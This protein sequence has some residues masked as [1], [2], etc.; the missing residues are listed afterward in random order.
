MDWC[1][2][3]INH[4]NHTDKILNYVL[5]KLLVNKVKTYSPEYS[6]LGFI[7][8]FFFVTYFTRI[9]KTT[10]QNGE[11]GACSAVRLPLSSCPSWF[12]DPLGLQNGGSSADTLQIRIRWEANPEDG[13]SVL[14]RSLLFLFG[15]NFRL[16]DR[17]A[18]VSSKTGHGRPL[19]V[20]LV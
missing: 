9:L 10:S 15:S 2:N 18:T 6:C 14:P 1:Y 8:F 3:S 19:W 11:V 12:A 4:I 17:R 7:Y 5:L 16:S 20:V 13:F